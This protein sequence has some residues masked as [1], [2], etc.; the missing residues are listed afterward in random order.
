M[1]RTKLLERRENA[2]GLVTYTS[3]ALAEL[4]VPHAFTTRRSGPAQLDFDLGKVSAS[5]WRELLSTLPLAP[6]TP[7]FGAL[8]VH[9]AEVVEIHPSQ[10]CGERPSADALRTAR[11]GCVLLVVTADCVPVLVAR[12][13]G[14]QVAAIHAGWRGLVAGVIPRTLAQ[15][16]GGGLVAAIGPCLSLERFEVGPE[17][18]D[19]F[20][21]ADLDGAVWANYGAKAHIDLRAA[22]RVQLERHGLVQIDCSES[23]TY[24]D[25]EFW[26]Y[27]RDVTHGGAQR[28]GRLGA[29]IAC[30]VCPEPGT[31]SPDS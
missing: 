19:A 6:Q 24:N 8:Q 1:P 11:Q 25:E 2:S 29:L 17:V 16:G 31:L 20:C 13:D 22:A 28:T 14:S 26:S 15:M 10:S 18:V 12:R 7:V 4:C 27:R 23:C 30:K 3:P 5:G 9:G 21:A